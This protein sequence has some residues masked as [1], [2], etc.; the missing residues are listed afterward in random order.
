MGADIPHF[1]KDVNSVMEG[2][3]LLEAL[4][5]YDSYQLT[6]NIKSDCINLGGLEMRESNGEWESWYDYQA[7]TDDPKEF[8]KLVTS[9][10]IDQGAD[11]PREAAS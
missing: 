2:I 10:E 6:N 11:T 5:E 3:A 7:E 9:G 8:L 1:F 4:A